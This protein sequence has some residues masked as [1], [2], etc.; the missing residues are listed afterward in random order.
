MKGSDIRVLGSLRWWVQ[1]RET[2]TACR[3][4]PCRAASRPEGRARATSSLRAQPPGRWVSAA[5]AVSARREVTPKPIG[6]FLRLG[7]SAHPLRRI[8]PAGL[9]GSGTHRTARSYSELLIGILDFGAPILVSAPAG[10][11]AATQAVRPSEHSR[12]SGAARP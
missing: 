1:T 9:L 11:N 6:G 7:S 12:K 3:R 5:A 8:Q 4:P 2:H 10:Q